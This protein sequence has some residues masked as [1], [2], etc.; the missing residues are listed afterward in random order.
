MYN[1]FYK[2]QKS[3]GQRIKVF[4]TCLACFLLGAALMGVFMQVRM[5][6]VL[7]QYQNEARVQIE[8]AKS[9]MEEANL[10]LLAV[11]NNAQINLETAQNNTAAE[12]KRVNEYEDE[13]VAAIA[14]ACKPGIVGVTS[15]IKQSTYNSGNYSSDIF[16][17]YRRMFPGIFG[18]MEDPFAAEPDN[19][20]EPNYIDYAFGSGVIIDAEMGYIIT[21]HHVID[22]GEK[23]NITLFD[24]TVI[25]AEV[26]GSDEY[27][28][29]ALL[30][31][32]DVPAELVQIKIGDS[33]NVT[34]G[35]MAVAIGNPLGIELIGT[36]TMGVISA[37]DRDIELSDGRIMRTIQTDA[38][39]NSGNSGGALINSNGELIGITTLKMSTSAY[40]S[41]SVEGLGF[42][43]PINEA[44]LIA[45]EIQTNG[46]V[47]RPTL[48]ISSEDITA[49]EARRMN[50]VAGVRVRS[51]TQGSS[52]DGALEVMDI[53]TK[54]NGEDITG[55]SQLQSKLNRAKIGDNVTL[56]VWRNGNIVE[57]AIELK[58]NA[59]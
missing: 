52:A 21:N 43:I 50:L 59:L 53:I 36:V 16:E 13:P 35:E 2:P 55:R 54:W 9:A 14:A 40:S 29:V 10:A 12:P 31:L 27:S 32:V 8:K 3:R 6:A 1:K 23:I 51:I 15:Q 48:G 19:G 26:I 11:R 30:K 28:D 57:V 39:I 18:G 7:S 22:G 33:T 44:M 37:T 49:D 46:R 17:Y 25:E 20:S 58:H 24:D 47:I 38:A 5:E 41:S 4:C 45:Q 42:A 56:T 34:V